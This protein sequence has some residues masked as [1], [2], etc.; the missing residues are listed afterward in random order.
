MI[1]IIIMIII[2]RKNGRSTTAKSERIQT[3]EEK[4]NFG[5]LEVDTVRQAEMRE[6]EKKKKKEKSYLRR[7]RKLWKWSSAAEISLNE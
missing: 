2:I 1:I 5:I 3:L 4:G 7:M 6:R